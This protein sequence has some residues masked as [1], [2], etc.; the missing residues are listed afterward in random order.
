MDG[1]SLAA[2]ALGLLLLQSL[3]GVLVNPLGVGA[4][5]CAS[6]HGYKYSYFD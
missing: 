4:L 2:A 5:I 3:R 1:Q 6:F